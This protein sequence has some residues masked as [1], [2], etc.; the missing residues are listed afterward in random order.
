[1]AGALAVTGCLG[2]TRYAKY[3]GPFDAQKWQAAEGDD[4]CNM[5]DD[6]RERIGLDG[7]SRPEVT[8]L[9]GEPE[10]HDGSPDHYYLCPSFLDVWILEVHWEDGRVTS[11][12]IRDT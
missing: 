6:L 3:P 8:A 10:A 5:V 11:T 7:K 2:E 1:M 12:R 4:R 9:L